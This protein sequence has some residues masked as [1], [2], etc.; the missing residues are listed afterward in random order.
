MYW[1]YCLMNG[2]VCKYRIACIL[3][4]TPEICRS[5]AL[6][7]WRQTLCSCKPQTQKHDKSIQQRESLSR[8][9][10]Q[11]NPAR[12]TDQPS[13]TG[14]S[15]RTGAHAGWTLLSSHHLHSFYACIT[16]AKSFKEG[17]AEGQHGA[18]AQSKLSGQ[19]AAESGLAGNLAM[20]NSRDP[21]PRSREAALGFPE[22]P[23]DD[24]NVKLSP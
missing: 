10:L 4:H 1:W 9:C 21:H 15:R 16:R 12:N 7:N 2:F 3:R 22:P 14:S 24:N 17:L 5:N 6:K 18:C 20:H 19:A 13:Q 11:A 8:W 23:R